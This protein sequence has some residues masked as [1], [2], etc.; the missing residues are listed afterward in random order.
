MKSLLLRI[1]LRS[2]RSNSA[3]EQTQTF[4]FA[5]EGTAAEV[6][7]MISLSLR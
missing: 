3:Q 6:H 4:H 2:Y 1:G 5:E 7:P